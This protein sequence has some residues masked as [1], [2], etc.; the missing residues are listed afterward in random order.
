M[1][2]KLGDFVAG[3]GDLYRVADIWKGDIQ[4]D[5]AIMIENISGDTWPF[6]W[7]TRKDFD[8]HFEEVG[9]DV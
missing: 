9:L 8:K 5:P 1:M 3:F 2:A 7:I 4:N 6:Q